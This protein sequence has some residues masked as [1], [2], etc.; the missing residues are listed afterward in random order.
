MG[1]GSHF[2]A[3]RTRTAGDRTAV[4]SQFDRPGN[5]QAASTPARDRQGPFSASAKVILPSAIAPIVGCLAFLL[6]QI[7]EL[8]FRYLQIGSLKA[9]ANE[10]APRFEACE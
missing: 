1:G 9:L 2:A 10:L 7:V 8:P 6:H 5:C 4:S 3:A